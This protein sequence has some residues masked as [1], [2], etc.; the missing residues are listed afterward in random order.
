MKSTGEVMGIDSNIGSAFLK[1]MRSDGY[2]IPKT[3][4]AF[5]S[6]SDSDKPRLLSIASKLI[7]LGFN[8]IATKGT[9]AFLNSNNIECNEIYKV[10][11]GRPNVVDEIL[12][13]NIQIVINSPEGPQSR[14]DEEAIGRTSVMKN[15]LTITTIS[16]AKAAIDSMKH[17]NEVNVKALQEYFE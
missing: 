7:K 12:N 15:V 3:G 4:T 6:V 10:G 14:F 9:Y 1:A 17:L 5:L 8:L 11:E 2:M 16:G 13:D